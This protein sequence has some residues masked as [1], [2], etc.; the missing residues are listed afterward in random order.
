MRGHPD[1]L[2]QHRPD[3]KTEAIESSRRWIV[4]Q[5]ARQEN[6]LSAMNDRVWLEMQAESGVQNPQPK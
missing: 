5:A 4:E 3:F 1:D 6:R 2:V